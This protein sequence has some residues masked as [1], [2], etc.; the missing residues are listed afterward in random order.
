MN[1]TDDDA[2]SVMLLVVFLS[3]Q[4]GCK[5]K[6]SQINRFHSKEF[7]MFCL[8]LLLLAAVGGQKVN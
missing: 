3:M 4:H 7:V 2:S 6:S 1:V 8:F 5:R